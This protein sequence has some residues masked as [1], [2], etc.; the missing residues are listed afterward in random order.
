MS[1]LAMVGFAIII[2]PKISLVIIYWIVIY[3]NM[4]NWPIISLVMVIFSKSF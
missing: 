4:V 1:N 2:L 3:L